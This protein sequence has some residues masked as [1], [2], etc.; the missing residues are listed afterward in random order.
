MDNQYRNQM[1]TG[2]WESIRRMESDE[3]KEIARTHLKWSEVYFL[4][5]GYSGLTEEQSSQMYEEVY[6]PMDDYE[7]EIGRSNQRLIKAIRKSKGKTFTKNLQN[8][9][10]DLADGC[11]HTA[12][13]KYELVRQVTG[14]FQKEPWGREIKGVWV[15]QW[16]VGM[17]GDSF[18][19][20]MYVQIDS[21]RFLK[22]NYSM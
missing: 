9:L 10:K 14:E 3:R 13:M 2:D 22:V 11:C 21:K 1:F 17:D 19:G 6:K 12:Q 5:E 20:Y 4:N 16:T 15:E 8:C 7:K 18:E